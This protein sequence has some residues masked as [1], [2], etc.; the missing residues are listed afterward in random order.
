MSAPTATPPIGQALP[1]SGVSPTETA[2]ISSAIPAPRLGDSSLM[3][4]N[5]FACR[6]GWFTRLLVW[7]E[8]GEVACP[9]CGA[10]LWP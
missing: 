8:G 6:C 1:T 7:P 2:S 10:I 5:R 4:Q 3:Y 9:Q